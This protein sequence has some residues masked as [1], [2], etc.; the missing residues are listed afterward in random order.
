[1]KTRI[2][3][4][5]L[6]LLVLLGGLGCGVLNSGPAMV[7]E[8]LTVAGS[9]ATTLV[10]KLDPA[11]ITASANG[12]V[13][14]PKFVVE[15]FAGTGVFYTVSVQMIGGDAS[16]NA[17][18]A[19]GAKEVDPAVTAIFDNVR[20]SMSQA[21][22]QKLLESMGL[23]GGEAGGPKAES[24]ESKTENDGPAPGESPSDSAGDSSAEV[25]EE[26]IEK[27]RPDRVT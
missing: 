7:K 26:F 8:T 10:S 1:M 19:G 5:G 17:A 20:D 24:R 22:W 16:F 9:T 21:D 25:R 15:G 13:N 6:C 12:S 27:P 23:I 11:A 18:G 4:L 2:E 14:N 3:M